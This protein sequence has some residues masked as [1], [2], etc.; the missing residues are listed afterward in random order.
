MV[1]RLH[2]HKPT[3]QAVCD[4]WWA[5]RPTLL[6]CLFLITSHAC[7]RARGKAIGFVCL[8]SSRKSPDRHIQASEQLISATKLSK[9]VKKN[10]LQY[11]L[12]CL[13]RSTSI[14]NTVLLLATPI[15]CRPCAFCSCAQLPTAQCNAQVR[16]VKILELDR[17]SGQCRYRC[18]IQI[19]CSASA[20]VMCSR[21]LQCCQMAQIWQC[22]HTQG[23]PIKSPK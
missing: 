1:D 10:W 12:N 16:I 4:Q 18:R 11:A 17:D 15:D 5:Y 6:L 21:E 22:L 20:R 23:H 7:T 19:R 8:S 3:K 9:S 14:T 13:A 2:V